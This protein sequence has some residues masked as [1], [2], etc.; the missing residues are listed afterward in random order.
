MSNSPPGDAAFFIALNSPEPPDLYIQPA[1][2][3]P[4]PGWFNPFLIVFCSLFWRAF[5][6]SLSELFAVTFDWRS[7]ISSSVFFSSS[8]PPVSAALS[9]AFFISSAKSGNSFVS[10][11]T[12]V[13]RP[14]L[15]SL[16]MSGSA[17]ARILAVSFAESDIPFSASLTAVLSSRCFCVHLFIK[18]STTPDTTEAT[19]A[20]MPANAVFTASIFVFAVFAAVCIDRNIASALPATSGIMALA[21]FISVPPSELKLRISPVTNLIAWLM[22]PPVLFCILI[23]NASHAEFN[24]SMFSRIVPTDWLNILSVVPAD[25]PVTPTS[26]SKSPYADMS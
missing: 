22:T 8:Y 10:L 21:R 3:P 20:P 19:V 9:A 14:S 23:R 15:P 24:V 16:L 13:H 4:L 5:A 12:V 7:T 17:A 11:S 6:I 25:S 2:S 18:V 26:R 1:L